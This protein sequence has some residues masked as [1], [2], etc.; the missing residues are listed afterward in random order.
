METEFD[1]PLVMT[2]KDHKMIMITITLLGNM[3]NLHI[4]IVI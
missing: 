4:K 2:K 3:E 1:K